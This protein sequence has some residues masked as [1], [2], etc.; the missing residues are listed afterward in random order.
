MWLILARQRLQTIPEYNEKLAYILE[1]ED[2]VME[3][4]R[5]DDGDLEK[6]GISGHEKLEESAH[7]MTSTT[8]LELPMRELEEL[9]ERAKS[10][11]E[12]LEALDTEGA[13]AGQ[14]L[15][16]IDGRVDDSQ[17]VRE[18]EQEGDPEQQE[19]R[20]HEEQD[21]PCRKIADQEPQVHEDVAADSEDVQNEPDHEADERVP[22]HRDQQHR[23]LE[24]NG[25]PGT[26]FNAD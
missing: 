1:D 22:L 14:H 2:F 12:A 23:E 4:R 9:K 7:P 3:R 13:L 5:G 24:N 10:V 17:Q 16:S 6:G 18:Q 15:R 11:T 25:G 20:E 19:D 21:V 26:Q 8:D